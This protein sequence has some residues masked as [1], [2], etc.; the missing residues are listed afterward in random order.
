MFFKFP[1][2]IHGRIDRI[3]VGE[4]PDGRKCL[5]I[6]DYKSGGF[7][8]SDKGRWV[9]SLQEGRGLQLALYLLAAA[10]QKNLREQRDSPP[11]WLLAVE[12][13]GFRQGHRPLGRTGRLPRKDTVF[14]GRCRSRRLEGGHAA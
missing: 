14:R 5:I 10:G 6:V 11:R 9:Q 2:T 4:T 3:D 1:I 7:G 12:Q 13:S 8:A